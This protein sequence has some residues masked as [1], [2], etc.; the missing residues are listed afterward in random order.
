MCVCGL[1]VRRAPR[2]LT[3]AIRLTDAEAGQL[4]TVSSLVAPGCGQR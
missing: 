4:A 3:A 2:R 1:F